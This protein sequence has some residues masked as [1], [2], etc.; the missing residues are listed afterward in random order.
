MWVWCS[1]PWVLG[2]VGLG[3]G[4][5]MGGL[6]GGEGGKR[7]MGAALV[8]RRVLTMELSS[9]EGAPWWGFV[10][11]PRRTIGTLC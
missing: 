9:G 4:V 7:W 2:G 3:A 5:G 6:G 1:Y 11:G 10:V 8:V